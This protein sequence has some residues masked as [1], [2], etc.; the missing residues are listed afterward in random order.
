MKDQDFKKLNERLKE[1]LF[2]KKPKKKIIKDF[3]IQSLKEDSRK[4]SSK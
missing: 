1:N 3:K 4:E 2:K